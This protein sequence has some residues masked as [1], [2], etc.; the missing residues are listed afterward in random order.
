MSEF[1]RYFL[2]IF[3]LVYFAVAF[4]LPTYRVWKRTGVNP[5][6]FRGADTAHDYIGKLF[7]IVMLILTL[8]VITYA[9]APNFYQYL[10]PIFWLENRIIQYIGIGLLLLSL[11]WTILA[12]I[13][14]G[15]SWRIGI[16]EEKETALVQTGLFGFSRNPIFLGMQITLLAFFLAAPNAL[17]LLISVLGFVLIQIQVRLEEEFLS[18]TRGANYDDYRRKVRRWL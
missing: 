10:L 18:K 6:T 14:M 12:Q 5:V 17:T 7:K 3:L 15:N 11:G 9:F 8:T 2:P 13:Q 1:L 16:D 4:V